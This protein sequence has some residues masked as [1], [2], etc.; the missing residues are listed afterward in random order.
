MSYG[1]N[2]TDIKMKTFVQELMVNLLRKTAN[3]LH[4]EEYRF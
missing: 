2:L 4:L 1:I 3:F